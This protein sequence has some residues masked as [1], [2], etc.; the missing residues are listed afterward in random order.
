MPGVAGEEI[1]PMSEIEQV[2]GAFHLGSIVDKERR[3]RQAAIQHFQK[4]A[5][6]YRAK[7]PTN[8]S[9]EQRYILG[10]YTVFLEEM[11]GHRASQRHSDILRAIVCPECLKR[12]DQ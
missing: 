9:D 8:A 10:T 1:E 5:E 7:L 12:M 11:M 6:V 3:Q 2:G 4:E